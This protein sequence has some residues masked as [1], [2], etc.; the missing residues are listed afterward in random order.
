LL[1][2]LAER[3]GDRP[4]NYALP[5]EQARLRLYEAIGEFLAAIAVPQ[6]LALLIDDLQ[7]ADAATLDLLC[8]I[9]RHRP[10]ARLLIVGAYREGEAAD[11]L[12]F[13][14]AAAELNRLR[15]LTTFSLG[16]LKA[17]DITALATERLGAPVTL[18]VGQILFRQ[19][20][21]NPFFAEELLRD[22][23]ETG[24]LARPEWS[25][26]LAAPD[27]AALPSSIVGAVRQRLARLAP[28]VIDVLRVAAIVGRNFE[29]ELLAEV[30]GQDLE[31]VEEQ[32]MAAGRA[33]LVE[34]RP[35]GTFTFSH[36]TIRESFYTEVTA[37]RRRRLHGVIGLA[38]EA[39]V[40]SMGAQ[41]LADLAFHFTR[42]GD[43]DRGAAYAQQAAEQAMRAYAPEQ[44][45]A[46][47]RA[48]LD[49]L[50]ADDERRGGMLFGLG[51][52]ATL[53]GAE[54]EAATAFESARDWFAQ[55]GDRWAAG[56]A[57][58]RLGLACW[59]QEAIDA[60]RAAFESALVLLGDRP[61]AETVQV[62]V[63]L[64]SLLAVSLHQHTEGIACGRRA[65]ELAQRLED[66]RLLAAAS[67]TVGNLLA[68]TND[69]PAGIALMEHALALATAADPAEA[70]E[71]CAV[72]AMAYM[73]T[74]QIRR[75][76]ER[77]QLRMEF[78][79]RCHDLFQLRHIYSLLAVTRSIQGDVA[80]A[81]RMIAQAQP[82]VERLAS[83]EPAAFLS[84][85]RGVLAYIRGDYAAAEAMLQGA[86]ATFRAI[87]PNALVW[88]L[89]P[90]GV[91]L[92]ARGKRA[93]ALDCMTELEA[94]IASLP[95]G[96]LPAA[97][98]LTHLAAMSLALGDEG[99]IAGYYT[100]LTPF[101]G[102]FHDL[103]VDRLLGQIAIRR[104]DW[105]TAERRLA[106]AEATARR[107]HIYPELAPT[108]EARADLELARGGRGSAGRASELLEHALAM[109]QP[110]G[111]SHEERR[112]RER[113][114]DLAR[115]GGGTRPQLLPAGLSAREAE[116][117][118][119]VATGMSNREIAQALRLSAKTVANHLT[120]I[121]TKTGADNRAAAAAFAI[122][123]GLA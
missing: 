52:A 32:L 74:G 93:E 45:L 12:A 25:W 77:T 104:G 31:G 38:L 115:H 13:Q 43:R 70:A 11:N 99:R 20:E 103:L 84:Y 16:P 98:P 61:R 112:L 85:I 105:A 28:E 102:Q 118:S 4:N 26:T 58:H 48:A 109:R 76:E 5:P 110:Y 113:L 92:L 101:A 62:L 89:G 86:I 22:W 19:S 57:A 64:G 9:A 6:S 123:H 90:L 53:A 46:H 114:R 106:A 47:Y 33:R 40:D 56:R 119:L 54:R 80:E 95:P 122:R 27:A 108:L 71:C 30:A 91:V 78:A 116:I 34:A 81:E 83:P 75:C 14:R 60:A 7:W 41:Q 1:P 87:G 3:L 10:A 79:R 72:L 65:L 44:A 94:L 23:I 107:E 18:P 39:R 63:D 59:R 29:A 120:N 2:D 67:R 49:L 17:D 35:D 96:T 21:G 36:D 82:I 37:A 24:A 15:V 117:L 51:E 68:L 97:T 66:T 69:L 100:Q 121:F 111:N 55:A 50:Q 42:S 73:A 88:Y 8:H